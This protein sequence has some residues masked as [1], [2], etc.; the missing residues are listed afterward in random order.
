M[1]G[2]NTRKAIPILFFVTTNSAL[3]GC[4]DVDSADIRTSGF[5]PRMQISAK[6]STTTVSTYLST[7]RAVDADNII[8]S[9]G[10]QLT[11]SMSGRSIALYPQG[12][13]YQ[14]VFEQADG[15][16]E[17]IIE[18]SRINDTDAPN[19]RVTL[20]DRFEITAPNA[21]ESF[22]SGETITTVWSPS[23]ASSAMKVSYSID[24]Q[25]TGDNGLPTGAAYGRGFTVDDTGTHTATIN[26]I[27]NVVGTQDRL[28]PDVPC[29]FEVTVERKN[30]GTID[31]AFTKGG[32]IHATR[33]KSVSVTVV[34]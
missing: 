15:G 6:D 4:A 14:G 9:P 16:S 20:P 7:G 24:C 11:A 5:Y 33:R 2:K 26:E 10:D 34:P 17:V 23:G 22:N 29:A 3:I 27:L 32:S 31:R 1:L 18:L 12:E 25:V 19:S 30:I 21:G 28:I 13:P 8:L